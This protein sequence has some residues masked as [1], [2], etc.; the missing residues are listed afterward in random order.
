MNRELICEPVCLGVRGT[1][2]WR[3]FWPTDSK[4]I[5]VESTRRRVVHMNPDKDSAVQLAVQPPTI[6]KAV[7]VIENYV[8]ETPTVLWFP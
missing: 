8:Y 1:S 7:G 2:Y 4:C 3:T 6:T 5:S